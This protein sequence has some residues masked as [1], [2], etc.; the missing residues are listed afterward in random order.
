[1]PLLIGLVVLV[2]LVCTLDLILTVG[3]IKRLR[4]H[5]EELARVD[6]GPRPA[7]SRGDAV[8]P[9]ETLTVQGERLTH[10]ELVNETVVAFFTP[11]CKACG[12]KLPEFLAHAQDLPGGRRQAVAVVVGDEEDKTAAY[13]AQF[14]SVARVVVEE[15]GGPI[16][17]AFSVIGFPSLLEVARDTRGVLVVTDDSVPMGHAQDRAAA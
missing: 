8:A 1:M 6:R 13:A 16:S 2:G 4:E 14:A 15:H 5:S 10:E 9:F 3:V 11:G 7:I 12:E 17:Q